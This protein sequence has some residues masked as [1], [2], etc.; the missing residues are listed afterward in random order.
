[1]QKYLEDQTSRYQALKNA[2]ETPNPGDQYKEFFGYTEDMVRAAQIGE[3]GTDD[4]KKY[5]EFI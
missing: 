2:K 1:M 5:W 4:W 3:V